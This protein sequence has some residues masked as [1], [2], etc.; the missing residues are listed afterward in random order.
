MA[1]LP[2]RRHGNFPQRRA[3]VLPQV[4]KCTAQL[5][6]GDMS[7]ETGPDPASAAEEPNLPAKHVMQRQTVALMVEE[8]VITSAGGCFSVLFLK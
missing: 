6:S 4:A 7:S 3:T 8:R 1:D 5:A 2:H